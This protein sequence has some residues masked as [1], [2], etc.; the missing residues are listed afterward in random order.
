M[1]AWSEVEAAFG[2]SLRR[3]ELLVGLREALESLRRAGCRTA[4]LDGSFVTAKNYPAD[5]DACWDA[6][7]VD[8]EALDP[9]LLDFSEGRRRQKQCFGGEL[10]PA[11]SVADAG[12]AR[13]LDYFQRDRRTGRPKGIVEID[14]RG[15][16]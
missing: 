9:V 1:A 2:G 3:E 5:F 10:F 7:G 6:R 16:G 11:D 12:G 15:L 14:L 13:F 8:P 4:F